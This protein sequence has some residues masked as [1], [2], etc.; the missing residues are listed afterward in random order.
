MADLSGVTQS[1]E[2][3]IYGYL[4]QP[5][6]RIGIELVVAYYLLPKIPELVRYSKL[7]LCLGTV[8]ISEGLVVYSKVLGKQS[9]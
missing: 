8:A 4:R 6:V 7:N 3:V 5:F 9:Y 2:S 1:S